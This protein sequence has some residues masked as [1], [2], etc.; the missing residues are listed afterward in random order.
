MAGVYVGIGGWNYPP[1][2]GAFYPAGLPQAQ[3]LAYASRHVTSIEINSTFYGSQKPTSFRKWR[4]ETPD[5]FVFSV[6]GPRYAT[7]RANLAEA[8]D[9]IE[10]FFNSGVL[11]LGD[12]LGP[13]LWQFPPTRRFDPDAMRPFLEALPPA[14]DGRAL[15]HVIEA[16]HPSFADPAWMDLL[17]TFAVA[18]AIVESDKHVLQADVTAPFVYARL[19]RN[20]VDEPEG[21]ASRALDHWASRVRK[22]THGREVTDL[23][24]AGLAPAGAGARECFIYFISG[25]KVRAPASATAFL[26]RLAGSRATVAHA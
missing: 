4:D 13:I 20:S 10:R 1:W 9:S 24:Q 3:E 22:W 5:E 14:H 18:H 19:E 7:H 17:R 11:E 15:R 2:R 16:R 6:K 12:K 8:A 21:Y 26:G 25:D 23:P